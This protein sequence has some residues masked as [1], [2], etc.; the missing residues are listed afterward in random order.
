MAENSKIGWTDH[1]YNPWIGCQRVSPGCDNCYA[2]QLATR[3]LGVAWGPGAERRRVQP[4]TR[5]APFGWHRAAAKRLAEWEER[6]LGDTTP[7]PRRPR[8]FCASLAD[9]WDKEAE[10]EWLVDTLEMIRLTPSLDW[11]LLTKRPQNIGRR[12]ESAILWAENAGLESLAQ[13]LVAWAAGKPPAHV[14]LGTTAENQEEANRRIP[15]LLAARAAVRF[16]S[17]EPLLGPL[18]LR[19]IDLPGGQSEV[20]PLGAGWLNRLEAG[21]V[22]GPR[23]DWVIAGGESGHGARLM[24]LGWA[25]SL[26]HQCAAAGVAFFM[27]QLGSAL[28]PGERR[29]GKGENLEDLPEDLRIRQWPRPAVPA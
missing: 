16:L 3:R 29:T 26:R 14:W 21:E 19:S 27:K 8:V 15:H 18:N 7:K 25:R 11:L 23:I 6:P 20:L 28:H 4:K 9:I 24:D 5:R 2:E 13:W 10:V 22:E 12:M 17:C 1:T